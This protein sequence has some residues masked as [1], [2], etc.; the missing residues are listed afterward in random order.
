MSS[1]DNKLDKITGALSTAEKAQYV[2]S[3]IVEGL[4]EAMAGEMTIEAYREKTIPEIE[5]VTSKLNPGAR[6]AFS[7]EFFR[8]FCDFWIGKYLDEKHEAKVWKLRF[9]MQGLGLQK[10]YAAASGDH[11]APE[12]DLA[13]RLRRAAEDLMCLREAGVWEDCGKTPPPLP[14]DIEPILAG[15]LTTTPHRT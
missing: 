1:I 6:T 15:M 13:P 2:V 3:T 8:R 14:D 4:E 5:R 9:M 12:D 7:A 10:A 11:P